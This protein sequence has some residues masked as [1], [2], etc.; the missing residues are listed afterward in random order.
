MVESGEGVDLGMEKN[1]PFSYV[2]LCTLDFYLCASIS[3]FPV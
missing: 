2:F 3:T 1:L